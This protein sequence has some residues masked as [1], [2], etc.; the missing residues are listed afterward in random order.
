MELLLTQA[1]IGRSNLLSPKSKI[2]ARRS[3]R[4]GRLGPLLLL[5]DDS[6]DFDSLLPSHAPTRHTHDTTT[7]IASLMEGRHSDRNG[8]VVVDLTLLSPCETPPPD[9]GLLLVRR[10]RRRQQQRAQPLRRAAASEQRPLDPHGSFE[11]S[12]SSSSSEKEW[13][14]DD[15]DGKAAAAAGAAV[16][17]RR[18]LRRLRRPGAGAITG[19]RGEGRAWVVIC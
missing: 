4:D 14:D 8:G 6:P 9:D 1:S 13:E 17:V 11:F 7:A 19:A 10:R 12:P 16:P 2:L 15:D 5:A 18:R 3:K